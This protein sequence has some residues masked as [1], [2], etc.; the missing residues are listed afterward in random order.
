MYATPSSG[1]LLAIIQSSLWKFTIRVGTL[2]FHIK[3]PWVEVPFRFRSFTELG[4]AALNAGLCQPRVKIY[5]YQLLVLSS[6]SLFWSIIFVSHYCGL[7]VS[8][9]VQWNLVNPDSKGKWPCPLIHPYSI[10]PLVPSPLAIF[11][12]RSGLLLGQRKL[13]YSG[14]RVRSVYWVLLCT[15]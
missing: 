11:S 14:V 13:L 10:N 12:R 15:V 6:Y 2:A 4:Q 5:F 3:W 1:I 9:Q 8:A 7:W